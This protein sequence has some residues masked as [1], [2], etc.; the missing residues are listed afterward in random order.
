MSAPATAFRPKVRPAYAWIG[1][2]EATARAG[3]LAADAIAWAGAP[4]STIR[5]DTLSKHVKPYLQYQRDTSKAP[6]VDAFARHHIVQTPYL[7]SWKRIRILGTYE[8]GWKGPG[9]VAAAQQAIDDAETFAFMLLGTTGLISPRIGLAADGEYVFSWD[10]GDTVVDLSIVGDGT[11]S[12][13]AKT[14]N[15]V[16]IEDD[17]PIT[18]P[19]PERL[20]NALRSLDAA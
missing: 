5:F 14:I 20:I 2:E 17:A 15:D 3:L 1:K 7:N 13:Y 8:S 16:F 12:F 11:Y 10:T 18:K 19:L 9:S 4:L 6:S